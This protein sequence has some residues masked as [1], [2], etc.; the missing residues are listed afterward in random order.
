MP[1]S[2]GD[3]DEEFSAP[4]HYAP[5][6]EYNP[7]QFSRGYS[8]SASGSVSSPTETVFSNYTASSDLS[9]PLAWQAPYESAGILG[10]QLDERARTPVTGRIPLSIPGDYSRRPSAAD[11]E[12]SV[13]TNASTTISNSSYSTNF[14]QVRLVADIYGQ[15]GTYPTDKPS[16]GADRFLDAPPR[17]SRVKSQV[18]SLRTPTVEHVPPVPAAQVPEVVEVS[19]DVFELFP[20]DQN[21]YGMRK[22]LLTPSTAYFL[23]P[24]NRRRPARGS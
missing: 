23:R 24:P 4:T 13:S 18:S 12:I 15:L 19:K 8:P 5:Q 21:S 22:R 20:N 1:Y 14:T 16:R 11:T 6:D 17:L 7:P 2:V 10:R 9:A 3:S